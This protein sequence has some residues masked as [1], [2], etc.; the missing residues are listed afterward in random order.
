MGV[1]WG[2]S[3]HLPNFGHTFA[4]GRRKQF[5]QAHTLIPRGKVFC[6]VATFRRIWY[7]SLCPL[8]SCGVLPPGS[9]SF[10]GPQHPVPPPPCT[11]DFARE[12]RASSLALGHVRGELRR[13][14]N[15]RC[16]MVGGKP[17]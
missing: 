11:V 14:G 10:G 12:G 17:E 15:G 9:G 6:P 1:G 16:R 3:R 13:V 7:L 2:L 5:A 4:S 8:T